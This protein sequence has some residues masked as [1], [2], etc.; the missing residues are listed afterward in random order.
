[1]AVVWRHY[2]CSYMLKEINLVA[3]D[4]ICINQKIASTMHK[5]MLLS[6]TSFILDPLP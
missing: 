6:A 3:F 5:T 1:M 4:N 2:L